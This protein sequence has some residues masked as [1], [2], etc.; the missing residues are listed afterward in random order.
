MSTTD[1][2]KDLDLKIFQPVKSYR[3][4]EDSV[5]IADFIENIKENSKVADLGAGVGIISLL[6]CKKFKNVSF[7][8]VEIQ[9]QLF[10]YLK[11]NIVENNLSDFFQ[12]IN[13][14]YRNL[15]KNFNHF[16][17]V[18]VSN[19]PYRKRGE[20]R[21]S[22][23]EANA[24]SRHETYGGIEDLLMTS[25]RILKDK[26][27]IYLSFL[28]ERLTDLIYYMRHFNMEPKRII[29]IYPKRDKSSNLIIVE[30]VKKGG[31]G[32]TILPPFFR[33]EAFS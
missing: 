33:R 32:L 31:K 20:G 28:S 27:R 15:P 4:N 3:Y 11:K 30:G 12:P 14:D 25:E 16:F 8:P 1:Y 10:E 24:I 21:V 22:S 23:N 5:L 18:V 29:P 2:I 6:L 9:K 19:P 7:Y 17:N 13:L 26:G